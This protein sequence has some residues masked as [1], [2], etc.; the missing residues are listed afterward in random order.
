MT[1]F[2]ILAVCLAL[3]TGTAQVS[4]FSGKTLVEWFTGSTIDRNNSGA[5][6]QT[7]FVARLAT[8]ARERF[9]STG[10]AFQS[11]LFKDQKQP[12]CSTLEQPVVT[13]PKQTLTN[14]VMH[15][16]RKL[17]NLVVGTTERT[18]AHANTPVRIPGVIEIPAPRTVD[19]IAQELVEAIHATVPANQEKELQ[20]KIATLTQELAQKITAPDLSTQ[21]EI[22]N[23]VE[24]SAREKVT[25]FFN[26]AVAKA[27]DTKIYKFAADHKLAIAGATAVVVVA[28]T[29]YVLYKKGYIATMYNT[30]KKYKKTTASLAIAALA[31]STYAY[32]R[33]QNA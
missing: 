3:S 6:E 2:R 11:M 9:N 5:A 1:I 20:E 31:A 7:G 19:S 17:Q 23:T 16:G 21:E 10:T 8:Q 33:T 18:P 22:I 25:Q 24:P 26:T 4:A 30:V 14:M 29:T 32:M 12:F 28:G 13:Q 27:Q 15:A